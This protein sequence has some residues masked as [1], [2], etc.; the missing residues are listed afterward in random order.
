MKLS[1]PRADL[2][3]VLSATSK[4]VESR[5]TIAIL[6]H[7]LLEADADGMH[8]TGSDLDITAT[9]RC[10]ADVIEEGRVCVDAKLIGDIARKAGNDIVSLTLE[11]DKLI[12]KSGRSRFTLQTLPAGDFPTMTVGAFATTFEIDLAG[13]FAPVSFA[14]AQ[15][16]A[17]HYLEGIYLHVVEHRAV[18]VATNG[19]RLARHV[20]ET[21]PAFPSVIVGQKTV[22]LISA[23]KGMVKLSISEEL[24]RVNASDFTI[25]SR[26]VE[27]TYPDYPRVI[28]VNNELVAS[29]DKADI[30]KAADRVATVSSE[31]G[32]AVKLSVVPG[33]IALSVRSVVGEAQDEVP[34]EYSG[35]PVEIGFNSI[36]LRD[37]LQ[38][39]PDGVVNISLRDSGSPALVTSPAYA[40]LDVTLMPMRVS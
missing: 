31:R 30:L 27:G 15:D 34:A 1:L 39:F 9:A 23:T 25:T 8:V 36:Y 26:L 14:I 28:P 12:V 21:A 22:S 33:S 19:H 10:D 24:I 20:G 6:S 13:L 18:A 11:G 40:S 29:A 35:E 5:N 4:V 3:R 16:A 38:V 32:S 2:A 37:A 7:L 17:R